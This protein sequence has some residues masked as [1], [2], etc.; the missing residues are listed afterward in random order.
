MPLGYVAT[1]SSGPEPLPLKILYM[2]DKSWKNE[3]D[4]HAEIQVFRDFA[5]A[6]NSYIDRFTH[7]GGGSGTLGS[8]PST[9]S[10]W[11]KISNLGVDD[12][13]DQAGASRTSSSSR[14]PGSSKERDDIP[15][16]YIIVPKPAR[17]E[18]GRFDDFS[19]VTIYLSS[20]SLACR[21]FKWPVL[22]FFNKTG[23][24]TSTIALG[25]ESKTL[26]KPAQRMVDK[27]KYTDLAAI[28]L[29]SGDDE[30]GKGVSNDHASSNARS[31]SVVPGSGKGS[32][33]SKES[34]IS[35]LVLSPTSSF[36][37]I[38]GIPES[39]EAKSLAG[40]SSRHLSLVGSPSDNSMA[41]SPADQRT[42]SSLFSGTL[43]SSSLGTG[44]KPGS[45]TERRAAEASPHKFTGSGL[46]P[47][48]PFTKE[49]IRIKSRP[50][51][52][53]NEDT[54]YESTNR[55]DWPLRVQMRIGICDTYEKMVED[56]QHPIRVNSPVRG[57]LWVPRTSIIIAYGGF[58]STRAEALDA[59]E[60]K[61]IVSEVVNHRVGYLV[62]PKE[63]L[64]AA[65]KAPA[66]APERDDGE[67][68]SVR[69]SVEHDLW[70]RT[71]DGRRRD[72][73]DYFRRRFPSIWHEYSDSGDE[74]SLDD[75]DSLSGFESSGSDS[76]CDHSSHSCSIHDHPPT[77]DMRH[78][79][80]IWIIE[81]ED[82]LRDE[83]MPAIEGFP[84]NQPL[85]HV[86][87]SAGQVTPELCSRNRVIAQALALVDQV[88][89]LGLPAEETTNAISFWDLEHV[90]ATATTT[91][92]SIAPRG[93]RPPDL[94]INLLP[95][96]FPVLALMIGR[97]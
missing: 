45:L 53:S 4:R 27:A 76:E 73:M 65:P 80:E 77:H 91:R 57:W 93:L 31:S 84:P 86:L 14:K 29:P 37:E 51:M 41:P 94:T 70:D 71:H 19:K 18:V 82:D 90:T 6:Y 55:R 54:P 25:K 74:S 64:D 17:G 21:L 40:S 89:T 39:V 8:G 62:W 38:Q 3:S 2:H 88:P 63:W 66:P 50:G 12:I 20:E 32:S 97:D 79:Q 16:R 83:L 48:C 92:A 22:V 52:N 46:S 36:S 67:R 9:S 47:H 72:S 85:E 13:G 5:A 43:R 60:R 28:S 56:G 78:E 24:I 75:S 11:S 30:K 44:D 7:S 15:C 68:S 42:G 95:R 61:S 10:S 35:P 59:A 81:I 87:P 33:G 58:W 49:K 23:F 26:T 34:S 96:N 69:S 1:H